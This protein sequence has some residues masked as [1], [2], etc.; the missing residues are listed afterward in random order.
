MNVSDKDAGVSLVEGPI[1]KFPA[2]KFRQP[3]GNVPLLNSTEIR[4][5]IN[6]FNGFTVV[7]VFRQQKNNMGTLLSVNSP[8]RLTP[9]FQLTSNSKTG[10]ISL[11]YKLNSS[12]KLRQIDWVLPR[13]QRKSPIAGYFRFFSYIF[14]QWITQNYVLWYVQIIA[15]NKNK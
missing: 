3:Y 10:L 5:A 13:Q 15:N 1:Q 11:K 9:W 4:S 8:G 12:E 14:H 7:F 6:N 2:F